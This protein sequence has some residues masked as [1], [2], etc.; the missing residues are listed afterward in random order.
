MM[1]RLG[2]LTTVMLLTIAL[3]LLI[4]LATGNVTYFEDQS[5]RI[6]DWSVCL[7]YICQ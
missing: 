3:V 1:S 4:G 2:K 6:Y 5:M 7:G